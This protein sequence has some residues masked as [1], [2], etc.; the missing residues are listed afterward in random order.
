MVVNSGSLLMAAPLCLQVFDVLL[1]FLVLLL[2]IM[3]LSCCLAIN[4]AD[5]LG[6]ITKNKTNVKQVNASK[7]LQ[8][9]WDDKDSDINNVY[10]QSEP[11]RQWLEHGVVICRNYK[12]NGRKMSNACQHKAP[13]L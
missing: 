7:S 4:P 12:R 1:P 9:E 2:H 11:E 5:V 13:S 8:S 6:S 3:H 10:K